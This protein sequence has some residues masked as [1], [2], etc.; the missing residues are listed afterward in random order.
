MSSL[1]THA[2]LLPIGVLVGMFGTLIGAGGGFILLPILLLMY[3]H[4]P[5]STLT[6]ISLAVVFANALSGSVA[7]A[8][9]G[10]I[11]YRAGVLFSAAA[12][13]GSVLGALTTGILPRRAFDIV[14]GCAMVAAGAYL[15]LSPNGRRH[16]APVADQTTCPGDSVP[17]G[18]LRLGSVLSVLVGYLSS[19]LGI[20]GGIIHV[21]AMVR[22]LGFPVHVATATSHFILAISALAGTC[23]HVV[24]GTFQTGPHRTIVLALGVLVG[25]PLGAGFSSRVQGAWIMRGLALA[26]GLAGLRV[27]LGAR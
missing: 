12:L 7:Y 16:T 15:L 17:P 14:F 1:I 22:L 26:L 6:S 9:M 8:R 10:R 23:A 13:P 20:G 4:E 3:P 5:P 21:P 19:L 24:S 27:L 11:H 18:S 2:W 25:A